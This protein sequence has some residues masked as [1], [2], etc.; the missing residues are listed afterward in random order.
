MATPALLLTLLVAVSSATAT[1][2]TSPRANEV[3]ETYGLETSLR[4]SLFSTC[5][6]QAASLTGSLWLVV[7]G[8]QGF[9]QVT[10]SS[11]QNITW[12][13]ADGATTLFACAQATLDAA[14]LMFKF[15]G[16][17]CMIAMNGFYDPA[18]QAC[19]GQTVYI[20]SDGNSGCVTPLGGFLDGQNI[21][22]DGMC[23]STCV[24]NKVTLQDAL[25]FWV[26]VQYIDGAWVHMP[27]R[28]PVAADMWN[29]I[30]DTSSCVAIMPSGKLFSATCKT[31]FPYMCVDT[32]K[33]IKP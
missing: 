15:N 12:Q 20:G 1:E 28:T 29:S 24:G 10:S 17:S 26:N 2:L 4:S 27:S 3:M 30:I 6:K 33:T 18:N 7:V 19:D 21:T 25:A 14:K 22:N 13:V 8:Q 23:Y 9:Y 31:S 5:I 32:T 11:A 16:G